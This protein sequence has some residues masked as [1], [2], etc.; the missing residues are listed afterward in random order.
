MKLKRLLQATAAVAAL[1]A[2]APA[3]AEKINLLLDWGWLPYHSFFLLAQD[4]G[5]YANE[6]LEVNIEQGR[7]SA[8]TA[9]VVGQGNFDIGHI[10]VT[11]TAQAIAKGVPLKNI[12]IYQHK[13]SASFI[14]IKGRVQL[15]GVESLKKISIGS[16]PGGSDGLSLAI[17][18]K[19]N[20]M[21]KNALNI[22]SLDANTKR[23]ALLN[24]SIDAVSGDSHAYGALVRGTGKEAEIMMLSDYGVDLIGFGFAANETFLKK[25][26]EAVRKFLAATKRGLSL[27][28]EDPA[29]ACRFIQQKVLIP[30][31]VEQCVDYFTG[32]LKLSQSPTDPKW[33]WQTDEEW[34]RLIST[35]DSV[36]ELQTKKPVKDFFTNDFV[37][38]S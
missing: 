9:L 31:S 23:A 19:K 1:L 36:G 29:A 20:N 7:G 25:H 15:D 16:T 26:P 8:S 13:S 10:N 28:A 33:G 6:G 30:G 2:G 14:G 37:P 32:L 17:L 5:F 35:L 21:D 38:N 34:T 11:N 3:H 24:G 18:L 4:R 27:A 22:V 12:A